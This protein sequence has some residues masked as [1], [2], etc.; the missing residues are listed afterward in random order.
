MFL[1]ALKSRN[2]LDCVR[3]SEAA[4]EAMTAE[5]S[6]NQLGQEKTITTEFATKP[7][8]D[9]GYKP[10][11]LHDWIK[12]SGR[13]AIL[14]SDCPTAYK[15]LDATLPCTAITVRLEQARAIAELRCRK[16]YILY[17]R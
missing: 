11:F 3:R 12:T 2:S 17:L 15:P 16:S 9:F 6:L 13:A 1:P 4:F 8:F 5:T 7:I 10:I 14:W